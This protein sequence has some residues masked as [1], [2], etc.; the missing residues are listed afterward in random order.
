MAQGKKG[1]TAVPL[2]WMVDT[3]TQQKS[4]SFVLM[5]RVLQSQKSFIARFSASSPVGK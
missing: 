3:L 5:P 4:I 2:R 1:T